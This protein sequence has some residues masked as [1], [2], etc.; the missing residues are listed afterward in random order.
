MSRTLFIILVLIFFASQSL[1]AVSENESEVM[2][3]GLPVLSLQVDTMPTTEYISAPEG[4]AGQTIVNNDYVGCDASLYRSDTLFYS[5]KGKNARLRIRGNTSAKYIP[6]PFKLKLSQ[7]ESLIDDA[8]KDKEWV[9]LRV[10]F[11]KDGILRNLV[12]SE[13]AKFIRDNEWQPSYEF[14]NVMIN[15]EYYGL[16]QI[17]ETVKRS[18]NKID[19]KKS[20]FLIEMDSYFWSEDLYF[21]TDR[22]PDYYGFTYKYPD[23]GDVTADLLN[24][25]KQFLNEA[26]EAIYSMDD[27]EK[28]IDIES[29]AKWHLAH[30]ILGTKDVAGSNVYI[31]KE[32]LSEKDKCRTKLKMGPLW[33]FDSSFRREDEVKVNPWLRELLN[34]P[35]FV[36]M[37]R[38]IFS[39]KKDSVLVVFDSLMKT[40][41]EMEVVLDC[42]YRQHTKKYGYHT[43]SLS[44]AVE[45]VGEWLNQ[46]MEF[47]EEVYAKKIDM[48]ETGCGIENLK[49]GDALSIFDM[50]GKEIVRFD[51]GDPMP[52]LQNGLYIVR[53]GSCHWKFIVK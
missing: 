9:L 27:L 7:K 36:D 14:V 15:D 26:E 51:Y 16:Y 33:D 37:E 48:E 46:R 4:C 12:G 13:M 6:Y 41:E 49:I 38:R 25:H 23:Y 11:S 44:D 21:R 2:G 17:A 29:F 34:I 22:L 18:D 10:Q 30:Q 24:T 3:W 20:G 19:I 40:L 42:S 47:L 45:S 28:Y 31:Y 50:P 35:K 8:S 53:K 32:D 5:T 52:E 39:Q 1:H 43:Q